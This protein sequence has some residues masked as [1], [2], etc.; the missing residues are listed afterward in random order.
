MLS[1]FVLHKSHQEVEYPM[2][3]VYYQAEYAEPVLTRM[4]DGPVYVECTDA[5]LAL[6]PTLPEAEAVQAVLSDE[7]GLAQQAVVN[8]TSIRLGS[9]APSWLDEI[10]KKFH[11]TVWKARAVVVGYTYHNFCLAHEGVTQT[12]CNIQASMEVHPV[13]Q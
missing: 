8:A 1:A 12:E 4:A 7:P 5:T 9:A 11:M 10:V 6:H 2:V 13:T 3:D